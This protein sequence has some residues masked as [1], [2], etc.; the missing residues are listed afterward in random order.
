MCVRLKQHTPFEDFF[1]VAIIDNIAVFNILNDRNAPTNNAL[2]SN[3][4]RVV[5]VVFFLLGDSSVS[6]FYVRKFRNNPS[7]FIGR[8]SAQDIPK[9]WR[10]KFRL[11]GI[12]Q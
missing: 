3:F 9:H 12:T 4:R 1:S 6:E 11:R 10:I 2:I 5:N 8:V 7:I